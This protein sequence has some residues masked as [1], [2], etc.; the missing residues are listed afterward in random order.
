M[1]AVRCDDAL[2]TTPVPA[3]IQSV[4]E[5]GAKKCHRTKAR[6]R[7]RHEPSCKSLRTPQWI[8]LPD[9]SFGDLLVD[10]VFFVVGINELALKRAFKTVFNSSSR[11]VMGISVVL[12]V[13]PRV[14]SLWAVDA[15]GGADEF[16][17]QRGDSSK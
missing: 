7:A 6:T 2:N 16:T 14:G 4:E 5:V 1:P 8:S 3:K 11:A 15:I 10:R 12:D 9:S 17:G 13:K